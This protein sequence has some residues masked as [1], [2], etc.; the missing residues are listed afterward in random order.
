MHTKCTE[1]TCH[2]HVTSRT[3]HISETQL[4]AYSDKPGH[5]TERLNIML[6]TDII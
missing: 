3:M 6:F 2:A 5:D 4:C 1:V